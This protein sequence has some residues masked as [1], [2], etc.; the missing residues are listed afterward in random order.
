MQ[1]TPLWP[2]TQTVRVCVQQTHHCLVVWIQQTPCG[3]CTV[4]VWTVIALATLYQLWCV[5]DTIQQTPCGVCTVD[6][7][8]RRPI[9]CLRLQIILRKRA[10]NYRALLR[11]ITPC[12][13]NTT[14]TLWCVYSRYPTVLTLRQQTPTTDTLWCVYNRYREAKTH[15]MPWVA[16]NFPQKSHEL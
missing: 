14:D 10:T 7:E 11:N 9:G 4:S 2:G 1:Q 16:G 8:R 15:R 5:C 3:V 12:G 13:V 6:T